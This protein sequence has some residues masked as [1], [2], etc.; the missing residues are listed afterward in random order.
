M[1]ALFHLGPFQ[2]LLLPGGIGTQLDAFGIIIQKAVA[3]VQERPAPATGTVLFFQELGSLLGRVFF[4]EVGRDPLF[5][6]GKAAAT[7]Q[8]Q[9]NILAGK[10]KSG[11]FF[12]L[13]SPVDGYNLLG[14]CRKKA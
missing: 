4:L 11:D 6:V 2:P 5:A 13:R 1:D 9:R 7:G 3:P 14:L 8:R 10:R 12:G